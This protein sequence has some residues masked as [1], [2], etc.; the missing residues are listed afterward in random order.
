VVAA[1]AAV[2]AV[3]TLRRSRE[4]GAASKFS[5]SKFSLD[6]PANT[7]C[8]SSVDATAVDREVSLR[9]VSFA[10]SGLGT[11]AIAIACYVKQ[12]PGPAVSS[13]YIYRPQAHQE[14]PPRPAPPL[15]PAA[16]PLFRCFAVAA[17]APLL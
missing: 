5:L 16:K 10:H 3:V 15:P 11:P 13:N 17:A 4:A 14:P 6:T 2:A 1:V 8:S 7:G 12:Q 9:E